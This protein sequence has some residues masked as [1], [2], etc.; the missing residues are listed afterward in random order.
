MKEQIEKEIE[1]FNDNDDRIMTWVDYGVCCELF[2]DG[3][4]ITEDYH[5]SVL[6]RVKGINREN[7]YHYC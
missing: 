3:K 2:I 7:G 1:R 6:E 4:S 5:Y